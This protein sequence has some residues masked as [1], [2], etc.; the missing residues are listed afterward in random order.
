MFIKFIMLHLANLIKYYFLDKIIWEIVERIVF[1]FLL[2]PE[3]IM[4]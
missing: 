3:I 1:F 4:R 2:W